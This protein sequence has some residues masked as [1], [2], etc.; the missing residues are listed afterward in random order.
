MVLAMAMF[1]T[2]RGVNGMAAIASKGIWCC[3]LEKAMD[4]FKKQDVWLTT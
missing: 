4:W 3:I 2:R 1:T